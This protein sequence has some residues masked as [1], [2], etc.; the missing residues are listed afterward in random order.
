M[1]HRPQKELSRSRE[2]SWLR[3]PGLREMARRKKPTAQHDQRDSLLRLGRQ[4]RRSHWLICVTPPAG[5]AADLLAIAE[6][7][8][9]G[10][11]IK[12]VS[13]VTTK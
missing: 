7:E 5:H 2:K 1:I 13:L 10:L 8:V 9:D 12:R 3:R 6:V 11:A 4:E